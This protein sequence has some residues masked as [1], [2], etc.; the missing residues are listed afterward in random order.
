YDR[1]SLGY[2]IDFIEA[3]Y[4]Q[5]FW[6]TFNLADTAISIGAFFLILDLFWGKKEQ[7]HEDNS[8]KS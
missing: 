6:P 1:V 7:E 5:N 8:S 4:N 3:H 2:V